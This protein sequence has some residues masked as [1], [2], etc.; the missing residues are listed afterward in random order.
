MKLGERIQKLRKEKGYS[1]ESFAKVLGIGRSTLANYEQCKRDPTYE[2]IELIADKLN[3]TPAYLMGWADIN[4]EIIGLKNKPT[5]I[6]SFNF[7]DDINFIKLDKYQLLESGI[8]KTYIDNQDKYFKWYY[9]Y[10]SELDKNLE[11]LNRCSTFMKELFIPFFEND[12]EYY[13]NLL[14]ECR[15]H[16]EIAINDLED[17]NDDL[18]E[19][20]ENY[21]SYIFQE[22]TTKDKRDYLSTH[23]D[24]YIFDDLADDEID[25]YFT[26]FIELSKFENEVFKEKIG[27]NDN[28]ALL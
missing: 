17:M 12:Y 10:I 24:K 8:F 19:L 22:L 13:E 16:L 20:K 1:Q 2:M 9:S 23:Q 26:K 27:V 7:R 11:N 14:D 21:S 15:N 3:T 28:L 25:K 6:I 18:Y 4:G 5:S